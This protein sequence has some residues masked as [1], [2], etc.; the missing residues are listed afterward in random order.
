M[1]K[2]SRKLQEVLSRYSN[3]IIVIQGSPDPDAMASSFVFHKMCERMGVKSSIVAKKNLSLP[4]N[5]EFVKLLSMPI[6]FVKKIEPRDS[7]DAY[8]ILDH[9]S[10]VV[11]DIIIPCAVHIDHH[12]PALE[13]VEADFRILDTQAGSTCTI[14]ALL[15]KDL[16]LTFDPDDFTAIATALLYGIH[17]D[18]DK[19]DHAG[20][21][22]Y[23]ALNYISRYSDNAVLQ[24]LA[25]YP[26]S[27]KTVRLIGQAIERQEIYRDWLI[28]GIGYLDSSERDSLPIIADYLLKRE[29]RFTVVVYAAVEDKERNKLTLEASFRSRKE[30]LNLNDIIKEITAEGGARKYKG[31][32]QIHLDY[33]YHCPDRELLW[34]VI[35][36]TTM[37]VLKQ[38][39]DNMFITELKGFYHRVKD[40]LSELL[41]PEE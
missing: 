34:N 11:N 20:E 13:Q 40:A 41:S 38:R 15:L 5:R 26:L 31:A 28:A 24:K 21:K 7:F 4:V 9:Q 14:I 18:T 36:N 17:S 35:R 37:E 3:I 29:S 10:A 22:D 33:F 30:H 16:G 2:A 32:Y 6:H 19:Y 8:A 23:E 1:K 39:R 25:E 12:I 27:E